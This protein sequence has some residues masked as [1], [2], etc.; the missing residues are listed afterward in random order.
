MQRSPHPSQLAAEAL[1]KQHW[2]EHAPDRMS[3]C[4]A[5]AH[6]LYAVQELPTC[7][8]EPVERAAGVPGIVED[9]AVRLINWYAAGV[10]VDVIVVEQLPTT[11]SMPSRRYRLCDGY[12]RYYFA[13]AAGCTHIRAAVSPNTAPGADRV[14][15]AAPQEG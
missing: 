9:R 8:I 13:L 6:R 14:G 3:R 5:R 10:E 4:F 7:A 11:N 1:L 15:G 2:P 12:H